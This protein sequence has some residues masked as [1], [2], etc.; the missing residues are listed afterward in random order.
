[1][2]PF[3]S[4]LTPESLKARRREGVIKPQDGQTMSLR[5]REHGCII[6]D[7]T[8]IGV[9]VPEP[10]D[11]LPDRVASP[12]RVEA[13]DCRVSISGDSRVSSIEQ[14]IKF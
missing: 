7:D 2:P 13:P 4:E 12:I 10:V 11:E 9:T 6:T 3:G 14:A 1:M 8:R 5:G